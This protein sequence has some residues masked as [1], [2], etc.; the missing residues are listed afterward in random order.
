MLNLLAIYL[1]KKTPVW[2]STQETSSDSER[3]GYLLGIAEEGESSSHRGGHGAGSDKRE[4]RCDI[5][6][7][8]HW[9]ESPKD[10]MLSLP[11]PKQSVYGHL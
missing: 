10:Q 5:R 1:K 6:A 7:R 2:L 11:W 9:T 4:Y 8:S 3:Y